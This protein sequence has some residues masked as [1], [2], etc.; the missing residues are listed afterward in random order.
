MQHLVNELLIIL[1]AG[2]LAALVCR[3]LQIP[4]L[5]GYLLVG[6][7][8]GKGVLG[9]VTDEKHEI[10]HL[11]EAGVSCFCFRLGWS[12]HSA[13]SGDSVVTC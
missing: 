4:S 12:S 1:S 5:V 10:A 11:A 9:W 6:A 8:I 13:N 7:I 3:R 2:L